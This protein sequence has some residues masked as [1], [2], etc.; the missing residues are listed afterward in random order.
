MNSGSEKCK[1]HN[2]GEDS[3]IR[4][5][6][7]ILSGLPEHPMSEADE[8]N[9]AVFIQR[10]QDLE[11]INRLV[12]S[13]MRDAVLYAGRCARGRVP[14]GELFSLCYSA[15]CK[16][17]PRF[18]PGGI[19]FFAYAKQDIRGEIARY[20]KSLDVVKNAS[21]HEDPDVDPPTMSYKLAVTSDEYVAPEEAGELEHDE[22]NCAE[23]EFDMMNIRE[24]LALI[25]PLM[26]TYLNERERT[27]LSLFYESDFNFEQI[28]K[29]MVPRVS[30][31]AI[32]NT[33]GRALRK[34]RNALMRERKLYTV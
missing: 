8:N 18:R 24:R 7:D 1:R 13:V 10:T 28:C 26:H 17:A 31:S 19:R 4:D 21:L 27:V 33:H 3:C 30:R 12:L 14:A 32:Q 20:W 5:R 6:R 16:A 11:H 22:R 9:C 29:M 23:P 34:I 25:Q 2:N 15:L